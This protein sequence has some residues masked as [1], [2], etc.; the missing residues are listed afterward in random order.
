MKDLSVMIKRASIISIMNKV[1]CGFLVC[2]VLPAC[3]TPTQEQDLNQ[4]SEDSAGNTYAYPF[5]NPSLTLSERLDDLSS[6]LTTE[7]KIAQMSYTAPA[8]DRLGIP[9]YNWWNE[10][11]HGV[12]RNGKATVFPQAIAMGASFDED[13][14]FRIATA[15][16]D[17]AR[18]KYNASV[19]NGNRLRYAGLTFW[20]PNVNIFR[21][22]RW[23]RGQET[24]GEDPY[25]SGK[26]GAAF[27]RGLQGNNPQ[28]LKAAACAK[29]YLV[30][31]GPEKDRHS[32]NAI[33]SDKDLYETYLPA[34]ESLVSAGVEAVMCAYNRTNDEACCGSGKFLQNILREELGFKGH[35]VSDCWALLNFHEQHGI[36]D[37]IV[38]SAALALKSGVNLNC[39]STYPYLKEALDQG[40][41]TEQ[42]IDESFK[43]LFSTRF[44][45]GL[46]DPDEM[47][48][49]T[50]ISE[51]VINSKK[52][53]QL[54]LEAA[55]K[56]IVLLK[57]KD[58][59]LP[60]KKDIKS[61]YLIGP[62]VTSGE[63][64]LGN[65][66]GVSP[67]M[68]TILEGITN[69]VS[70]GTQLQ[71][72][73]GFLL[74]RPNVNPLDWTSGES[75]RSNATIVTLGISGL[76]EGE[77][78]ESIASPHKGDMYDFAIPENQIDFLRKLRKDNENPIIV[79]VTGGSPMN[80]SEI[81]QLAD[82]VLFAWYPGEKGGQAVADIVFGEVSPSGRLPITFPKSLS[83][84]PDYNDYDMSKRTY[85][86]MAEDP[87]Y[88]F[89][90][91]LSYADFVYSELV[92]DKNSLN[93]GEDVSVSVK[94]KNNSN[95]E[96]REVVQLYLSYSDASYRVPNYALKKVK[97]VEL[98]GGEEQTINFQLSP[99]DM[100]QINMKGEA[101]LETG[102]FMVHVGGTS[103]LKANLDLA[104]DLPLKTQFFLN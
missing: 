53:Q 70:A 19:A 63:I 15:I 39:G 92:L 52:H 72:K 47:N 99:D 69:T 80:L 8:V 22:P 78:G 84:L 68:T 79:V 40:L 27:V 101:V 100:K 6:R 26:L 65:Y 43:T 17:E 11:L 64:L 56:G 67:N 20:S 24:Y 93:A 41:V 55:Q 58:N 16:S 81:N 5:L 2:F 37:D 49:Y 28:Y 102:R 89:G 95:V 104:V 23:G 62:H 33:S 12:A 82:A 14:I 50:Q 36:T 77:E 9:E 48:P 13:L 54:A 46:F 42:M 73:Y 61:L 74:D 66:Y 21:D 45:L 7:E 30:H 44:K 34:F 38:A 97:T 85:K 31:S 1:L 88:P 98:S 32:F 90:Y 57:N 103:P 96:A 83:Q 35:I 59:V 18:A 86:Y 60:L 3:Q 4:A 71:Y 94:V 51:E 10:A 87:L 76:L 91:G 25:L 75:K 29:H